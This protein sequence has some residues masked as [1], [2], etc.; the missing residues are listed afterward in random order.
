MSDDIGFKILNVSIE[1]DSI[2]VRPYSPK[3]KYP[4]DIY[5]VLNINIR[6]LDQNIDPI[7]QIAKIMKPV[8]DYHLDLETTEIDTYAPYLSGLIENVQNDVTYSVPLSALSDPSSIIGLQ[9][10]LSEVQNQID[11]SLKSAYQ[12]TMNQMASATA[13]DGVEFLN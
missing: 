13:L 3:F 2:L 12:N 5:P 7:I 6:K 9:I 1:G 4:A 10:P 11:T 8:V